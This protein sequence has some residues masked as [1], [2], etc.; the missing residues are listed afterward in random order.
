[1]SITHAAESPADRW[2]GPAEKSVAFE[3]P[4]LFYRNTTEYLNGTL[5]FVFDGLSRGDAVLIA[6]PAA[7]LSL[8][9]D[10]LGRDAE[11]VR[12]VDLSQAGRNPGRILGGVLRTFADDNPDQ[13]V[14][15]VGEP[16]WAERSPAEYAACAQHEALINRAFAG[17]AVSMLCPY[18][19]QTLDSRAL[20]DAVRTHPVVL[21]ADR[22]QD[23][24]SYAPE[25][26]L[27]DYNQPLRAPKDATEFTVR[28]EHLRQLRTGADDIA[29]AAGL[30]EDGR[31][32]WSLVL[33]E[34]VTNSIEHS[35]GRAVVRMFTEGRD[36]VGQVSDAGD[37]TDP[38][39]GR[40]PA[41]PGQVRGR[42]LMIVHD[43]ADLVRLHTRPGAT[44]VEVRFRIG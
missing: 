5:A 44:T 6:V 16:L 27:A 22:R 13:W 39:A 26:V 28:A 1:M 8:I 7:K 40:H 33:T 41:L 12:L 31:V 17:R 37:L 29:T 25:Q 20:I 21:D 23:S 14:R 42:G 24:A 36:L 43:L 4:A 32:D 10:Q 2:Q 3:H 11:L 34:L 19:T 35:D 30:N 38:L 15:I 9:A 18:D